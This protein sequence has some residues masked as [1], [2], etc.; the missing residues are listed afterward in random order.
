MR[1]HDLPDAAHKL[2]GEAEEVLNLAYD[3]SL[4]IATAESC[5]GGLLASLLT[6]IEGRSS[7]FERGFVTYSEEAKCELLGVRTELIERYTAVSPEVAEAMVLGALAGSK[8]DVACSITGFAGKG[9][10][11]GDEPGLVYIAA[12]RRG[13]KPL[14]EEYH[15]GD[16]GREGVRHATVA[17]ALELLA[18]A[19]RQPAP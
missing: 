12:A 19:I 3:R 16:R 15:F 17:E 8:A 6:D 14:V 1:G 18:E 10:D 11:P 4:K 9:Q 13:S 2:A 7:S 5:T